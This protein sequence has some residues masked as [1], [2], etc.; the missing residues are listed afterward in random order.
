MDWAYRNIQQQCD[1]YWGDILS[2]Q[3]HVQQ[4]DTLYCV[5]VLQ[6]QCDQYWVDVL[7]VQKHVQQGNIVYMFY[8]SNV[9]NTGVM[10][11]A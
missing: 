4:G 3:K 11:W 2:V 6:Q 7:S 10:Y 9:T 8:S 5:Y 1:K